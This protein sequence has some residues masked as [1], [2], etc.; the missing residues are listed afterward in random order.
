MSTHSNPE[1][2]HYSAG[3]M[4]ATYADG[5][6]Q[7]QHLIYR[8]KV[9][10]QVALNG[11]KKYYPKQK[12][13]RVLELGAAEGRTLLHMHKQLKG[14]GQFVGVELSD[15]LLNEAPSMPS[16][17]H[18]YKGDVTDLPEQV[19]RDH[20]DLC[21]VLAVLEHLS[22]P[23]ACLREAYKA[24]RPGGVLVATCPHPLWDN[25]AGRFGLVKD[26]HHE[27]ELDQKRMAALAREAG[28]QNVQTQPF[29]WVVSGFLPYVGPSLPP[30]LSLRLDRLVRRLDPFE[31][32]FVNQALFAQ[33]PF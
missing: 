28:F 23:V 25:I 17:A 1:G 29:M 31:L 27:S 13:T 6:T 3:V 2:E 7:K 24:L 22:D 30:G 12:P 5:R 32:S 20:F 14:Q 18:L 19:E 9:R 8:Y 10:A 16:N 15:S 26:E 33:K 4:D 21:T 11:Y